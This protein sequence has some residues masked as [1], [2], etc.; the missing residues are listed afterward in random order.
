VHAALKAFRKERRNLPLDDQALQRIA[1]PQEEPWLA[2]LKQGYA[3]EF[4]E[5][6][7]QAMCGLEPR[8]RNL[9]RQNVIDGL[10][11]DEIGS[12]YGVH[13]ATAARWLAKIRMALLEQTRRGLMQRLRVDETELDSMMRLARSQLHVSIHRFLD[14]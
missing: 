3:K 4:K 14:G 5:A 11:I 9:L 7:D 1:S 13:R 6:F 8:E 2:Q 12:L 10:S